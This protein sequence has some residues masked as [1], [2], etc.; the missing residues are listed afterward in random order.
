MGTTNAPFVVDSNGNIRNANMGDMPRGRLDQRLRMLGV[1]EENFI[2][3]KR[4]E[5]PQSHKDIYGK[6]VN[7]MTS[8]QMKAFNVAEEPQEIID[9][10][11]SA[12]P[13][14]G[15]AGGMMGGNG[16]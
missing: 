8:E 3:S 11:T 1:I 6:A 10:Y 13:V 15:A 7:L 14:G 5:L 12:T 16:F 9:M 4:G 2:N